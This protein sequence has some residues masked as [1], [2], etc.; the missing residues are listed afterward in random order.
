MFRDDRLLLGQRGD[1]AF[2]RNPF[3]CRKKKKG[4]PGQQKKTVEEEKTQ[5][6]SPGWSGLV[7]L[8]FQD[9]FFR[10][11]KQKNGGNK[12]NSLCGSPPLAPAR[13]ATPLVLSVF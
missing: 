4:E 6:Y 13:P 11:R 3:H 7:F 8:G 10:I 1:S 2:S 9:R 5:G 12:H